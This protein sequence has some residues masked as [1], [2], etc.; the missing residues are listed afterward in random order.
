MS[1]VVGGSN[2]LPPFLWNLGPTNTRDQSF[3]KLLV[4]FL[5]LIYEYHRILFVAELNRIV[6]VTEDDFRPVNQS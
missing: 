3:P 6:E 5:C 4:E 1:I 2:R